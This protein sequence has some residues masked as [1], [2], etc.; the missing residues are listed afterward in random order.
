M[1]KLF[2]IINRICSKRQA[3]ICIGGFCLTGI[4]FGMGLFSEANETNFSEYRSQQ[5]VV[6]KN[7]VTPPM[8][9]PLYGHGVMYYDRGNQCLRKVDAFMVTPSQA[10]QS[11]VDCEFPAPEPARLYLRQPKVATNHETLSD[12]IQ[13]NSVSS[14][15]DPLTWQP[16]QQPTLAPPPFLPQAMQQPTLAPPQFVQQPMQQAI[17]Q[18]PVQPMPMV[19]ETKVAEYVRSYNDDA[20]DNTEPVRVA[21]HTQSGT[22]ENISTDTGDLYVTRDQLDSIL[23]EYRSSQQNPWKKGPFTITPYGYINVSTSYETERTVLGDFAL[24]SRSPELDGGGHSGFHV[25]PKSSRFGVKVDGPSFSWRC[26]KINTSALA[27][28]DFQGS[29]YAGTRNRGA[30]M[31][32]RAFI[33]LTHEDIRLLIGQEWDVVS[34]L[35]PQ[36]L[37]YVPGSNAGNL[38]YRRAQIRLER[39]RKWNDCY[40]TIWQIALCDNVPADYLTDTSVNIA[41]SGWPLIQGRFAVSHR[42]PCSDLAP[43]TVGIS[44]HAG[45]MTHDYNRGLFLPAINKRRHESWSVNLDVDIPLTKRLRFSTE[46]YTGTNLSGMLAGIGQGVDLFSPGSN[47]FDPRSA[48]AYGGWANL[49][50]MMTK[51]FQM[52][53]G[54]SAERMEDMIGSTNMG[55]NQYSARDKNQILF[56]NGIYNWTDNFM[57]GLEVSQWRTDWHVYDAATNVIRDVEPGETTRIDFLVRYSF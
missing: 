55:N 4:C 46:L 41:N 40:S 53:V 47:Q 13:V 33:D 27:E 7:D 5:V 22:I 8:D 44:A 39:N 43:L 56:L 57:T 17:P 49:N 52:N 3:V 28:V 24:Y 11:D 45:E 15:S 42:N 23:S 36:S 26:R 12:I 51:K 37:N 38:G 14:T 25:D 48:D 54:Y 50:Y 9:Q 32:R 35:V 18:P 34:P 6:A 10:A 30:L 2:E 16:P 1:P 31:L 21:L 29:N 19:E 20:A